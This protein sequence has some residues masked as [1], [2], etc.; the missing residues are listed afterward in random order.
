MPRKIE[1]PP[2]KVGQ[3]WAC[4]SIREEGRS[5]EI[6]AIRGD[7]V[8]VTI[9]TNSHEVQ[10]QLD[11]NKRCEQAGAVTV[12]PNVFDRVGKRARIR[13]ERLRDTAN[14]YRLAATAA[15]VTDD[16]LTELIAASQA[17]EGSTDG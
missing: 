15:V 14:G 8:V 13:V 11:A 10:R 4:N 5:F 12:F 1:S 17:E 2:A 3:V 6:A 16:A 9:L 7:Y